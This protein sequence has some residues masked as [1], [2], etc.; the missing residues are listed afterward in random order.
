MDMKISKDSKDV[1]SYAVSVG[2]IILSLYGLQATINSHW[3][4]D[5]YYSTLDADG[6][7]S[8]KRLFGGYSG[9]MATIRKVLDNTRA[10]SA[11]CERTGDYVQC[12]EKSIDAD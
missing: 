5:F 9:C 6:R 10:T 8:C 2:L 4:R 11:H 7:E 12:M 1:V 3:E